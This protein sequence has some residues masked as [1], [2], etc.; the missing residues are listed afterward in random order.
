MASITAADSKKENSTPW[1]K[2]I[3][4]LKSEYIMA[5]NEEKIMALFIFLKLFTGRYKTTKAPA[6]NIFFKTTQS[7]S[8]LP[9]DKVRKAT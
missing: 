3:N 9:K 2:R 7:S 5:A 4:N 8:H 1:F 6:S